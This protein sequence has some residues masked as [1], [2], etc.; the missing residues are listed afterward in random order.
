MD[1]STKGRYGVR[2]LLDLAVNSTGGNVV[3]LA[4]IANRQKISE[5]YLEQII[6]ILRKSG[7]VNGIKGPQGGYVLAQPAG[8]IKMRQIL[9]IL[10]GDLFI[11]KEDRVGIPDADLMLYCIQ[12][13]LWKPM[14]DALSCANESITLQ[15][16][17]DAY[18]KIR[19]STDPMYYI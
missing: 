5:G 9:E 17:V 7:I 15:D 3:T 11:I 10:E 18:S 16:L 6:S 13:V 12:Q 8:R 19:E 2:A 1:M 4:S 14:L